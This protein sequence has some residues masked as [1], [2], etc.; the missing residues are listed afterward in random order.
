MTLSLALNSTPKLRSSS[1]F[2][3]R[4]WVFKG[5]GMLLQRKHK[6]LEE[7]CRSRSPTPSPVVDEEVNCQLKSEHWLLVV[8]SF[9]VSP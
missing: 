1:T 6:E 5:E 3:A 4:N 7:A 2:V 8:G 9:T